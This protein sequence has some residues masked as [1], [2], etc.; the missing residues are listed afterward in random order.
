MPHHML[1]M[2]LGVANSV[3]L[4]GT[5]SREWECSTPFLKV[6]QSHHHIH[7]NTEQVRINLGRGMIMI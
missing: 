6:E 1:P 3:S 2:L 4:I 7:E 5:F